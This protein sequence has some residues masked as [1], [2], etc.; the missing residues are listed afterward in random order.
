MRFNLAL[1]LSLLGVFIL[2]LTSI[3]GYAIFYIGSCNE[4]LDSWDKCSRSKHS[5]SE[6]FLDWEEMITASHKC[7]F[8]KIYFNVTDCSRSDP[9]TK[10]C[11]NSARREC[12]YNRTTLF[13]QAGEE[14]F[15][16][17]TL[18]RNLAAW[19]R[20]LLTSAQPREVCLRSQW[21]TESSKHLLNIITENLANGS[22][23]RK[24]LD[25]CK[26]LLHECALFLLFS[27]SCIITSTFLQIIFPLPNPTL[28]TLI[29]RLGTR[30][31]DDVKINLREL[32]LDYTRRKEYLIAFYGLMRSIYKTTEMS[33]PVKGRE[34][35]SCIPGKV[36]LR[37]KYPTAYAVLRKFANSTLQLVDEIAIRYMEIVDCSCGQDLDVESIL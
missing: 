8:A 2:S 26:L 9:V 36:P 10:E 19:V 4:W 18:S 23:M 27:R 12:S 14:M 17:N 1:C 30:L 24:P 29:S 31:D 35:K 5:S 22:K 15:F 6:V 32:C 33:L 25:S 28:S 11:K 16:T 13:A 7:D 34:C 21:P 37:M 20:R 3:G